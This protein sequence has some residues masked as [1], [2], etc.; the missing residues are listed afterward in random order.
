MP[1][2]PPRTTPE[3]VL[4]GGAALQTQL[5]AFVRAFGLHRP[6]ETPCGTPVPVSEAHAVSVLAEL[7]PLTQSELVHHL[8]LGKST[9]SRLVDQVV[10]RGWAVRSPS[11]DDARRRVVALTEAG[12]GAAADLAA[13]RARR[14]ARL[15]DRIPA[16]ERPAVLAALET[17]TEAAHES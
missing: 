14:M 3:G 16:H 2:T 11:T 7:G 4:P 1:D 13:N 8:G 5:V 6:D 9:V 10:A 15:L 17:L 12:A